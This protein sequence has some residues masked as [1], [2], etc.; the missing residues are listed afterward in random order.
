MF[1]QQLRQRQFG[2]RS[3]PASLLLLSVLFGKTAQAQTTP[4]TVLLQPR[5]QSVS[6]GANVTFRVTATGT[7]QPSFQW[8][9][10]DTPVEAATN[11]TFA[12]TNITLIQAGGY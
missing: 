11:S 3:I 4:P 10:N 8:R 2:I 1:N 12:L 5:G 7:P 9:W 6:L